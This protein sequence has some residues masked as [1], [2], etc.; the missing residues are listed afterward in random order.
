[1]NNKKHMFSH[2]S[3]KVIISHFFTVFFLLYIVRL[4]NIIV[5]VSVVRTK[6]HVSMCKY[7]TPCFLF[8]TDG[9]FYKHLP[10]P[11][12]YIPLFAVNNVIEVI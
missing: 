3:F 12:L 6:I 11:M 4:E 5:S 10:E 8:Y 7:C 9:R 1:M 2:C